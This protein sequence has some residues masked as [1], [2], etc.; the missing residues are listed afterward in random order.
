M[1]QY[2]K[3]ENLMPFFCIDSAHHESVEA[4]DAINEVFDLPW[5][6]KF[7]FHSN[8]ELFVC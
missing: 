2:Y 6:F 5:H 7:G 1:D 4:Q 3:L 8:L